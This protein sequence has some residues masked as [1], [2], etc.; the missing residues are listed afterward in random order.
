[1]ATIY[2]NQQACGDEI[3]QKLYEQNRASVLLLSQMQMGKSGTYWHVAFE[4]MKLHK[5]KRV[6]II[7]GNREKELKEQVIDDAKNYTR[8]YGKQYRSNIRILWGSTLYSNRRQ[9][10]TI[11]NDSLIIWD[12]A[13]Y[14]QSVSNTP[15]KFFKHNRMEHVLNGSDDCSALIER[16][17]RLLTVSATPFSEL[18]SH[19]LKL[20]DGHEMVRLDPT[21]SYIGVQ[22]YLE[23][24][25]LHDSFVI[26]ED[27]EGVLESLISSYANDRRYLIM[28]VNNTLDKTALIQSV[29]DR[30]DV[31][32]EVMNS[33]VQTITVA[34]LQNKPEKTTVVVISGMLR[35]GKVLPKRHIAVVFEERTKNN[36]RQ[37]DTGLQGL[38]GRV[39]GYVRD[40]RPDIHVYLESSVIDRA[41]E[42]VQTY[43]S[44]EG[45]FCDRAMNLKRSLIEAS[46]QVDNTVTVPLSD[47]PNKLQRK[48]IKSTVC[49]LYPELSNCKCVIKNLTRKCNSTALPRLLQGAYSAHLESG[50]Y[51]VYRYQEE[52]EKKLWL[53]MIDPTYQSPPEEDCTESLDMLKDKCVFK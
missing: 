46:R 5:V 17:I 44:A 14:A 12:E 43:N 18:S 20:F 22:F 34:Q 31:R 21:E 10:A 24:E 3:V 16:N 51:V 28:R 29:C 26:D 2:P 1:M 40:Y 38:L 27:H 32:C 8:V 42:Y 41:T 39:C 9:C 50:T 33:K 30:I 47:V 49:G 48:A 19:M 13:H 23:N 7:S 35:M 53:V 11:P 37:S 6:Y 15:Y 52:L 45:P 4:A 36:T 25:R